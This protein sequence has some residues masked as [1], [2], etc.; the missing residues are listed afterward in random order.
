MDRARRRW[1]WLVTGGVLL[2]VIAVGL[3]MVL[4]GDAPDVVD[5]ERALQQDRDDPPAATEEPSA[6]PEPT[7]DPAVAATDGTWV[8]DRDRPFDATAGTGTF[9]GYRIEEELSGIGANTAVGRTPAVEGAIELDGTRLVEAEI[10]A[11]LTGLVSD[12]ARRDR[13]VLS[14][15]GDRTTARFVLADPVELGEIPPPG[16][17]IELTARGVLA[18]GDA[19]HETEV[20]LA[21]VMTDRGPLVTGSTMI[22]LDDYGVEVPSVASVL[23]ADD[24]ATL[25]WQLFFVRG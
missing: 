14:M 22:T 16:E 8:V 6:T 2:A 12:D 23:A 25:E 20:A 10:A 1:P 4:G 24:E 5:P 13:R 17:V 9:V 7:S 15:L 18:I 21:V 3:S 19:E 11:E